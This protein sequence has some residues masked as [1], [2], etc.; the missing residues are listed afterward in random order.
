MGWQLK[1]ELFA[2]LIIGTVIVL[3]LTVGPTL[4]DL[5]PSHFTVDG[6]ANSY[7]QRTDFLWMM[8]GMVI[9]LYTLL[10]FL[11][12]IDPF[13]KRIRH[14]YHI[15]LLLRDFVLGFVLVM[16]LMTLLAAHDGRLPLPMFGIALGV[17]FAL[18]GN[19]L[20]KV[21]R[22]WFFGIR[23]PWT[24]ASEVVWE[25]THVLGGWM[26]VGSGVLLVLLSLAGAPLQF[27]LPITLGP[28]VLVAGLI[29]PYVI[30][31]H[32]QKNA[33]ENHPENL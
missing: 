4:P 23:N 19:Y 21:P 11:P 25:K 5:V 28:T 6:V 16:F 32:L 30:W 8:V 10:T 33:G 26:F 29:Y 22:N 9:G 3:A 13:W 14:R 31:R 20:P 2:F 7:L 17:L 24:L 27:A 1:R 18:I 15:L 12:F